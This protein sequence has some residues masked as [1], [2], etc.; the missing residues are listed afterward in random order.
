MKIQDL[1]NFAATCAICGQ[2]GGNVDGMRE[3]Y[4][5]GKGSYATAHLTCAERVYGTGDHPWFLDWDRAD[6][7]V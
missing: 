1:V 7:T 3:F 2:P 4:R 6:L 5:E